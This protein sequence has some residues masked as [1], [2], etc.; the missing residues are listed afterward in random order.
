MGTELQLSSSQ[1]EEIS[2]GLAALGMHIFRAMR[3]VFA[4]RSKVVNTNPSKI[5]I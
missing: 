2:Q 5:M 3:Q 4:D 1:K